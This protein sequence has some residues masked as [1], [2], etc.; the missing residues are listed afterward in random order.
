M[1][2]ITLGELMTPE[3]LDRCYEIIK[4]CNGDSAMATS[5]LKSYLIQFREQLEAKGVLPEYLAYGL[6]FWIEQA[7]QER[8]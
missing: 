4:S 2:T 6:P 3:Q 8:N 7:K 1:R 5:K